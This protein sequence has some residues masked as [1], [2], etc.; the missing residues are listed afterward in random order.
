ML[1]RHPPTV[2]ASEITP[3]AAY[4]GRRRFMRHAALLGAGM[5]VG[6]A[7]A[8]ILPGAAALA[9]GGSADKPN[10][11]EE[12]TSY[13][14]FYEYSS[15]KRAVATLAKN[16][17]PHPWTIR[18]E[19][20]VEQPRTIDIDALLRQLRPQERILRLRCV[21]G[22]SM[23][24]PWD[25]VPLADV[26]RLVQP[27]SR[28]RYVRFVSLHD[29]ARLY[30][31]R[32]A[33]LPWPYTEALT[34]AEA[35]HPLTLMATGLYGKPLPNQNGAPIRLVVPWKYGFKSIKS[36]VA[37]HFEEQQPHTTWPQVSNDYGFYANVNPHVANG[38]GSQSRENRIGELHKRQ[39][40]LFN[41][42][43][44]EVAHL[45]RGL[46]LDRYL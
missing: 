27:T 13:N 32:R 31:Q 41:G 39:T 8:G 10:S 44:S 21:E 33:T 29:P 20:E 6:A 40:Q 14:N 30:G 46:D 34:I 4:L 22:W 43:A 36:I 26:L 15:D 1:I 35:M 16:L 18:I 9:A 28:A 17:D 11:W 25:G 42:Y 5:W 7:S 3:E 37:I 24:I 12:I 23:V 2:R 19:G 38:R 45:Y